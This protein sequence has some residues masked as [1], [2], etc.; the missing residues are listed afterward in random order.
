MLRDAAD[1]GRGAYKWH[2][3][4]R[5]GSIADIG[6]PITDVRSTTPLQV[7]NSRT[8]RLPDSMSAKCQ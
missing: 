1:D 7:V 4:V 3:N 6:Q 2:C 5:F 8:F